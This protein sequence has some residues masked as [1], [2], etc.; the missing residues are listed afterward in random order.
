MPTEKEA[1]RAVIAAFAELGIVQVEPDG[2]FPRFGGIDY[3]CSLFMDVTAVAI[4]GVQWWLVESMWTKG[5]GSAPPPWETHTGAWSVT[6]GPPLPVPDDPL[7]TMEQTEPVAEAEEGAKTEATT[8]SKKRVK[9]EA[10]HELPVGGSSARAKTRTK[11]RAR[12]RVKLE[13]K[14]EPPVGDASTG[15]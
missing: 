9:T 6:P 2:L 12:K 13:A 11:T 1:E 7:K 4:R 15:V 10:K 5:A 3:S 14:S 8:G